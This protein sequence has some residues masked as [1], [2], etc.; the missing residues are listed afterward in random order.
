VRSADGGSTI[1]TLDLKTFEYH[2]SAKPKLPELE[3]AARIAD[4]DERLRSLVAGKHRAGELLRRAILPTLLYSAR[5]ADVVAHSIDDVDRAM[6]WGFGWERGPFEMWDAI[7]DETVRAHATAAAPARARWRESRLPPPG[8]GML[9]LQESKAVRPVVEQNAAA[10]L[11][12]LGDGVLAVEFHSKMNTIGG[13]TIAMVRR[14][15]E[16]AARDFS[17]LVI[18]HE[19]EPF[20]AGA[21]LA[22]LLM[23]AEDGEWDE[24]DGMVRAF[25]GMTSA[26]KYSAVPVVIAPVGLALG[27]GCEMC[28]HADRLQAAAETYMGLVEVGVGLVPAGGGTKEMVVRANARA[29]GGDSQGA[30]R[31]AFETMGFGRVSTSAEDARRL[32]FLRDVDGVT[33]NRDRLIGDAKAH[34]LARV[35]DGYTPPRPGDLITVGGAD[36]R[37]MLDLGV[38]LGHRAGRLSDHDVKIGHA[39]ARVLTGGDVAYRTAVSE[40]HLLD[41]EREAFLSLSAEP[42]TIERIRHTLKTGKTLRN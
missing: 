2:A 1:L 3:D 32:G 21:N 26:I 7:G 5:I 15:V 28:L 19:S 16:R 33:M 30:I 13:D 4:V 29:A 12:D 37:A 24:V 11:V 27:G 6:R 18:G 39:L 35:A 25:Q 34:A 14:G 36:A 42:R 23:A 10:S 8:P 9:V 17:A 38:H 22:L 31:A 41:L 40:S 20:S